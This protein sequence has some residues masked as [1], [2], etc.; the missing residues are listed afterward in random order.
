MNERAG[1]RKAPDERGFRALLVLG[2][3][4]SIAIGI[5]GLVWTGM[6]ESVLG[7]D[8]PRREADAFAGVARLY[9][10][11]ML[12]IGIGYALAAAQPHRSRSLLVPLFVVP[13]IT[14]VSVIAAIA[15]EEIATGR[16][17]VFVVY[18]LAFC[19]L[20]FRLYP[21]VAEP[22]TTPRQQPPAKP[23]GAP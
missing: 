8:V 23:A 17:I 7:F 5:W 10:G 22:E 11:A 19:L 20:Y 14:A 1:R 13:V 6:L 4:V 9:G 16:G 21:R 18:N 12:A 2:A 15:R 3:V